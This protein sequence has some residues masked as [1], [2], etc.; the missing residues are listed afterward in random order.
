MKLSEL[1]PLDEVISEHRGDPEMT[2]LRFSIAT[3][4]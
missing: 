1:T 4:L 3:T 2:L